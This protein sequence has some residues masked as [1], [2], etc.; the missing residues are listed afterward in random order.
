MQETLILLAGSAPSCANIDDVDHECLA[1]D[2]LRALRGKRSQPAFS[3]RLG[4]KSN[5]A[6]RWESRKTFP[7]AALSLR[8]AQRVGVD[9][10]AALRR[11]FRGEPEWM[12]EV[13]P[14]SP[15]GVAELLRYLAGTTGIG[16][17]ARRAGRSRFAVARWLKGE[18]EPRLPEFLLMVDAASQRLL[19]FVSVLVDPSKLASIAAPWAE[20]EAA[21]EAAYSSP[22]SH[23][24]LRVLE[25]AEYQTLAEHTPGWIATRLGIDLAEETRCL[26]LLANSR[27]IRRKGRR[28]TIDSTRTVDTRAD[29]ERSRQ[30]KA[31]WTQ[32]ALERAQQGYHHR[33]SYAVFNVSQADL[34]KVVTLYREFYDRLRAVVTRSE[35]CERVMLLVSHLVALESPEALPATV[36]DAVPNAAGA[37]RRKKEKR[38]VRQPPARGSVG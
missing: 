16:E 29:P 10:P 11:F 2:V 7:T 5:V 14:R 8:A 3:R 24:V 15:E 28:W 36:L 30:V 33:G 20:H 34:G 1:S 35:P 17:L 23:A 27:Q 13:D 31:W 21:R 25:L 32:V 26:E 19:D 4:F 6:Y 22:W 18:A 38:K 12:T 37:S 9:V